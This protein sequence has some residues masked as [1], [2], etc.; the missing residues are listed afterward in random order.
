MSNDYADIGTH[1]HQQISGVHLNGVIMSILWWSG[2]GSSI[3]PNIKEI[4]L[5]HGCG[6]VP[7]L[8]NNCHAQYKGEEELH[9]W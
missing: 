5:L 2:D 3:K 4:S 6:H 7:Q 9:F 8:E 1:H